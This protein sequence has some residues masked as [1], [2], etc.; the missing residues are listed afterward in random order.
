MDYSRY[1]CLSVERD[2]KVLTVALN[3]PQ[4]L[5]AINARLHTELSQVFADIAQDTETEAVLLTGRGRAFCAG[6]DIK[7]FQD[8]TR[9]N[10]TPCSPRRA[11]SSSTCS[12]SNSPSLPR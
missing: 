8:M 3:R 12:K 11:R 2:A 4:A 1:E 5:N 10:W 9:R 7:W 6:G